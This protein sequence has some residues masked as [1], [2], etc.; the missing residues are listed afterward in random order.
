MRRTLVVAALAVLAAGLS[1]MIV[2]SL[3]AREV[4]GRWGTVVAMEAAPFR[5]WSGIVLLLAML[6]LLIF[7]MRQ[8]WKD[9]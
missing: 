5:Y 3:M 7:A 1:A 6:V 2:I 9:M 4:Y 8:A